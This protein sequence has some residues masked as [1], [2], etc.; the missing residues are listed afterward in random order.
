MDATA[1]TEKEN[2]LK[3]TRHSHTNDNEDNFQNTSKVIGEYLLW[4]KQW[5]Q[6]KELCNTSVVSILSTVYYLLVQCKFSANINFD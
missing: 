3:D 5:L 6:V 2:D 1:T 4:Y